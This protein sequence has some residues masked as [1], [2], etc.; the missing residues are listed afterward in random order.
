MEQIP[1]V[2]QRRTEMVLRL[3]NFI[4]KGMVIN[5]KNRK[6]KINL[7]NIYDIYAN[8]Y[9][10]KKMSDMGYHIED[11]KLF[12]LHFSK[13]EPID[14]TYKIIYFPDDSESIILDWETKGWSFVDYISSFYVFR[15]ANNEDIRDEF[16][17]NFINKSM[18]RF[19]K[20]IRFN[21]ILL[22]ICVLVIIICS[23]LLGIHE[24]VSIISLPHCCLIIWQIITY[25]M[26]FISMKKPKSDQEQNEKLYRRR[27][28]INCIS[29]ISCL[30][31]YIIF[32]ILYIIIE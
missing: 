26:V 7:I 8:E 2:M 29:G 13:G 28:L 22:S 27:F 16:I 1:F 4:K 15:I 6:V 31:I 11:I 25:Y 9:Y 3:N 18:V 5:M 14:Y 19:K 23:I 30:I 20:R 24:P 10:F 32:F 17:I 21:M 12:T